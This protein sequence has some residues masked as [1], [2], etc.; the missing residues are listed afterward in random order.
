VKAVE[1]D[2]RVNKECSESVLVRRLLYVRF[3][4]EAECIFGT[5]VKRRPHSTHSLEIVV[6][7]TPFLAL[8]AKP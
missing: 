8:K 6:H 3:P 4:V 7:V 2:A 1:G 5:G